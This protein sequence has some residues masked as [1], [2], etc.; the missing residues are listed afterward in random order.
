MNIIAHK[1][2]DG[3]EQSLQEHSQNV[4]RMAVSFAAPFGGEKLAERIGLSHDAGKN[5]MGFQ[6][7]I[8]NP[9]K[10]AKS[11]HAV[12]G[13]TLNGIAGDF[14][15]AVIV[16]GHHS[17][18][19]NMCDTRSNLN[20][21]LAE[22]GQDV[23][24]AQEYFST[25]AISQTAVFPE[26]AR[27]NRVLGQFSFIKMEFSCLTDADYQDTERFMHGYSPRSY[28]Y[29][30]F[31]DIYDMFRKHIQPWI[32]KDNKMVKE[33]D[34]PL[35]KD[36]EIN[37]MRTQMMLQCLDA[38]SN[39][40]KGDI[41]TLSI[42]T[43]G[44]KT[45]SSFAY[46]IAAAKKDTSIKR[47]IVV[48][49]FNTITTQ[50]AS[51]LRGIVGEKNILENH[52]GFDFEDS[53]QGKL[54]Q[55]ASEN[56][57]IPIV[58]TTNV[59]FF[60]SF[61]SNKPAKS[62]KLHN[63]VDSVKVSTIDYYG[64]MKNA[65]LGLREYLG[66]S[67]ALCAIYKFYETWDNTKAEENPYIVA[68]NVANG[69]QC[70]FFYNGKP[71]F[72]DDVFKKNY[73]KLTTA[74]GEMPI[75]Q[76]DKNGKFVL[77]SK[78]TYIRSMISG[79][80]GL[81]ATLFNNVS[82]NGVNAYLLSNNKKNTNYFGRE[83]G[84]AIPI[85]QKDGHKICEA[86]KDLLTRRKNFFIPA[87]KSCNLKRSMVV[88]CDDVSKE[89]ES[90]IIDL[91]FDTVSN[92]LSISDESGSEMTE[93][94]LHIAQ[95]RKGRMIPLSEKEKNVKVNVWTVGTRGK[96]S[97]VSD[98]TQITLGELCEHFQRHYDN[99][100][101]VRSPKCKE[102]DGT[103][104]DFARPTTVYRSLFAKDEKG[105][106]KVDNP[107]LWK[108]ISR[109]VFMGEKYPV[110][111]LDMVLC[112]ADRESKK[113]L[114]DVVCCISATMAGIIKAYL[115]NNAGKEDLTVSLN[116]NNTTPAYLTGRIFAHMESAQRAIDPSN[117]TTFVK[118]YFAR[119]ME[120]PAETM[121]QMHLSFNLLRAKANNDDKKSAIFAAKEK[122]ISE[123]IDM[124]DD[125][126]PNKLSPEQQGYFVVG[127]YQQRRENI[128]C[129]AAL[130]AKNVKNND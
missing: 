5:T 97:I 52:S 92:S 21:A 77:P 86:A 96:G 6:Q 56:W 62:R 22:R 70:M 57:D 120:N 103:V 119:V 118:R 20:T 104:R 4:S 99:M 75:P 81:K 19:H 51:V 115:I 18:L 91:C 50:T 82:V 100:E 95:I 24:K 129:A 48:I 102:N 38:G 40:R 113:T 121:P 46:A 63:I 13:A 29:D 60:E 7:Y 73:E 64:A 84:N 71:I 45:L 112:R 85:S 109:S 108:Q 88:W 65:V 53:K 11:P 14:P 68:S 26:F 72:E 124:L 90:A 78:P 28:D 126:Y 61:F 83:K 47:I 110:R 127:Y 37:H 2:K 12:I 74:Y 31:S 87:S 23:V 101:I 59:Q 94:M 25:D 35:T 76:K 128:R 111:V 42:P 123:L 114:D 3:R 55:Y 36:E 93:R 30:S 16:E 125:N 39:S 98:F 9:G 44:S 33:N 41:R 80:V 10:Y 130:A 67:P 117:Q 15:S 116:E 105:K 89:E 69:G 8:R 79:E 43:G 58:V 106:V 32:D 34:Q 27:K 66:E 122:V 49:P 54:L 1:S 17:G 107:V